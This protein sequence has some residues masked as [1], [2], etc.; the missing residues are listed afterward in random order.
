MVGGELGGGI[1][2]GATLLDEG[3]EGVVGL[4]GT[5]ET[6]PARSTIE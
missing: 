1:L 4:D 5:A 6:D 3:D 2:E